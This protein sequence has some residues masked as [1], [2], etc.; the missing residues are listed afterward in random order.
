MWLQ[1]LPG[2]N[3]YYKL[4][5][6]CTYEFEEKIFSVSHQNYLGM[7]RKPIGHFYNHGIRVDAAIPSACCTRIF[8]Q[9]ILSNRRNLAL[10]RPA[11]TERNVARETVETVS[12]WTSVQPCWG[13]LVPSEAA[14]PVVPSRVSVGTTAVCPSHFR[15]HPHPRATFWCQATPTPRAFRSRSQGLVAVTVT[16]RPPTCTEVFLCCH[17]CQP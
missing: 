6:V 10:H 14:C 11:A 13:S 15:G 3:L 7:E 5:N 9:N 17:C 2:H 16:C 1:R 8:T 12:T 4:R